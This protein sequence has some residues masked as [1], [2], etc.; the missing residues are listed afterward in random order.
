MLPRSLTPSRSPRPP[1]LSSSSR[2]TPCAARAAPAPS[3]SAPALKAQARVALHVRPPRLGLEERFTL[4]ALALLVLLLAVLLF[5]L[6]A[7][8][9]AW[10]RGVLL[11]WTAQL[12][13]GKETGLP[14]GL[15]AGVPLPLVVL[16]SFAQDALLLLAGY[17][18]ALLAWRGVLKWAWLQQRLPRAG[19]GARRSEPWGVAVLALTVWI[20]FLPTGA[21][22]AALVGRAA[23]YRTVLLLPAL[24]VSILL[25]TLAFAAAYAFALDVTQDRILLIALAIAAGAT[26]LVVSLVV[27]YRRDDPA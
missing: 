20:P 27:R 16:A 14:V 23:G 6:Y 1:V 17:F 4:W 19:A 7:W 8:H 26:S 12:A 24:G 2:P 9:P 13:L 5:V 25:S 3:S 22:V 11:Q 18:L 21:L 10:L 15:A